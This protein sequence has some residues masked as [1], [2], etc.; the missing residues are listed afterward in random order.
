[1]AAETRDVFRWNEWDWRAFARLLG[2]ALLATLWARWR[3]IALW[4]NTAVCL[5]H[6]ALACFLSFGILTYPFALAAMGA[7]RAALF[8]DEAA[9]A[10]SE[11]LTRPLA[12]AAPFAVHFWTAFG[13]E[14]ALVLG[15]AWIWRAC[16][17]GPR[18]T[19]AV[20]GLLR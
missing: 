4:T 6:C 20:M 10:V 19:T 18:L 5:W 2:W 1:M 8:L 7:I 14:I 9:Y 15:A 11:H 13:A 16:A 17:L 12:G 3:G